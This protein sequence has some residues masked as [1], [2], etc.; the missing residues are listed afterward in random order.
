MKTSDALRSHLVD[1]LEEFLFDFQIFDDRFDHQV[2]AFH[3]LVHV[4]RG[5]DSAVNIREI[6]LPGLLILVELL[7][8]HA[9]QTRLNDVQTLI[10]KLLLLIHENDVMIGLCRDLRIKLA[11]N[12]DEARQSIALLEQCPSPSG[13]RRSLSRS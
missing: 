12:T 10:E 2:T 3:S 1:V 11:Q 7:L 9:F 5:L 13:L 8:H 4:R 6:L